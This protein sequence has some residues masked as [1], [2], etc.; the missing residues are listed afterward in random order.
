LYFEEEAG[1]NWDEEGHGASGGQGG[2]SR[3][4]YL[5]VGL[6]VVA[7]IA[8]LLIFLLPV[9]NETGMGSRIA[10]LEERITALEEKVNRFEAIDQ[11]VT[12]IWEQAKSFEKF[13]A[14]FDHT[15]ASMSLRMDHLT[16]SLE[17]LQNKLSDIEKK[18]NTTAVKTAGKT[19]VKPPAASPA[20]KYHRV[21][22]GETLFSISR[23]YG[24]SVEQ[25]LQLN[26]MKKNAVIK[27]G[28]KLIVRSAGR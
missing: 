7:A 13:K 6:V 3:V 19:K 17:S 18:I 9:R 15:E 10:A 1:E 23:R 27:P 11:K 22:A 4:F 12:R 26:K 14:R 2:G 21:K 25:L 8:A 20:V 5:L 28:Q 24:L 16:M